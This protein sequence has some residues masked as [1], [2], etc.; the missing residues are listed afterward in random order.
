MQRLRAMSIIKISCDTH[1]TKYHLVKTTATFSGQIQTRHAETCRPR[2]QIL[3][4]G[5][6][7]TLAGIK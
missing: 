2:Q 7:V 5:N 1:F 3:P 6:N 4:A